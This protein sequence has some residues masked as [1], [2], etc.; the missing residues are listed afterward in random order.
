LKRSVPSLQ[1]LLFNTIAKDDLEIR[2][3]DMRGEKSNETAK[4]SD[5][6]KNEE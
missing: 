5:L 3:F 4:T 6:M 2:D 1:I